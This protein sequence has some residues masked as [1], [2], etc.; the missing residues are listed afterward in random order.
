MRSKTRHVVPAFLFVLF[1][2]LSGAHLAAQTPSTIST[3][4]T[5][6]SNVTTNGSVSVTIPFEIVAP[7][8]C[9]VAFSSAGT[10][11][12]I[13]VSGCAA[14]PPDPTPTPTPMPP[15]TPVAFA[16]GAA[17]KTTQQANVWN[18][19][20]S[21]NGVT[22]LAGTQPNAAT[23]TVQAGPV[24]SSGTI[25]WDIQF[26]SGVSG[27]VGQDAM[28][29]TAAAPNPPPT[30][31]PT[32]TPTP[33]PTPDPSKKPANIA[34]FPGAQGGGAAS[35][36]GRGGVVIEVTNLND[37]GAGSLR[38]CIEAS[39]PRTCIFRVSGLI[40][41]KSPMV[42]RNPYIT[43]AG[44][45]APG[46]GIVQG[47]VGQNGQALAIETHDVI[48]RYLTYDGARSPAS[49]DTCNHNTGTVGYEILDN[50]NYNIVIDHTSHRW[51]GNKDMEIVSNGP[52]QNAHD[53]SIQWNLLYEPC[54]DH[55]VVTEPDVFGGGSQ[56]ASVNQDWHHNM[57]A[58][59][60]HRWPLL[61]IRSLRWVN[62]LG[63]NGI[64]KSDS[65]N[66]S[67]W[68]AI[69]ADIIGSNFVDGPDSK[70]AVYNIAIQPDPTSTVDQ[71]DCNPSCDNGPAQG[72]A[73]SLYLL[74]NRGHAG[75]TVNT[76]P[77]P[78]TNTVNDAAN[79]SMMAQVTNAEGAFNPVPPPASWLRS[80][81]LPAETYP[82]IADPVTNLDVV[83]LPTVG[84]S[85]HLDCL[86]N[87][88]SNRDSQDTRI[89][90]Q[91]QAHE[92]GGPWEGATYTG[93]HFPGAPLIS[94]G[95]PCVESLHDGIPDQW[96]QKKGLSI[97][98]KNLY[99]KLAPSGYTW[100]ETYLNGQ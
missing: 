93:P 12:V 17:V 94:A 59:Y 76:T 87:W 82:I 45:T 26:A 47:G 70:Q 83:L 61:S 67:G 52:N 22:T 64:Q 16:V 18:A 20:T 15:P 48:V 89:I 88:V 75:K 97:S 30:P 19:V 41:Q 71:A 60:N 43:I 92:H 63:Y 29:V 44:Q 28:I 23:G 5:T 2:I 74:N 11:P 36:G 50:N 73:P 32:P 79:V 24:N 90:A 65:F 57:A 66:F 95:T 84:N 62:N 38:A 55:P 46:G 96:K 7:A 35:V 99:K 49:G 21:S 98:D 81:P 39:G 34:A 54:I 69:Q 86:G 40:T 14:A 58:N 42:I 1:L 56:F 8:G 13:N 4:A 3:T 37:S 31:S 33:D 85:Q 91:Y 72:R 27:W 77:V 6:V 78:A 25:F 100:L 51:W 10:V 80:T 53:I 68:G 9:S